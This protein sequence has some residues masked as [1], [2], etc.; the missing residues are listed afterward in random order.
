LGLDN[1]GVQQAVVNAAFVAGPALGGFLCETCGA[2]A[3]FYAVGATGAVCALGYSMLPETLPSKTKGKQQDEAN[4]KYI[5]L[6]LFF[7]LCVR[8]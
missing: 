2:R 1:S 4:S 5:L 6:M 8:M 7:Y 3:A